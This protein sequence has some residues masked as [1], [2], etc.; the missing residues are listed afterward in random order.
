MKLIITKIL[1][2]YFEF[3]NSPKIAIVTKLVFIF[4]IYQERV[5][6]IIHNSEKFLFFPKM[7]Y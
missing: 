6:F 1:S 4:S 7:G 3:V 5:R 2:I